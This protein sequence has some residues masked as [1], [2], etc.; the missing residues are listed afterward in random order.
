[1]KTRNFHTEFQLNGQS[2]HSIKE[3]KEFAENY[4]S[5][6]NQL[7][8]GWFSESDFLEI[9]TSGSTGKPKTI[10]L[11]KHHITNSVKATTEYFDINPGSKALLCLPLTYVAGK[12]MVLRSLISGWK[13]QMVEPSSNPLQGLTYNFD[14]AAMVP[15]QLENS[16][17]Q[18]NQI[19][20]LIVG[21]G[22]VSES[23]V[24]KIQKSEC[25]VFETYGMTETITHI[26][27]KRLN[28]FQY[29]PS[30]F[31]VLPNV[32]VFKDERDCLVI[33]APK[34]YNNLIVTNDVVQLISNNQFKW[35]GRIDNVINSGGIKLHPEEIEGKLK[36]ILNQRF[37]VTSEK[38]ER[39]GEKLMIVVE[40]KEVNLVNQLIIKIKE[41]EILTNFEKPRKIVLLEQF[42]ET[43][44]GKIRRSETLTQM[45]HIFEGEM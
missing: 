12:L 5:E 10:R 31:E 25:E 44:S 9:K 36:G 32:T 26:A 27:V 16:I 30:H 21:G 3:V 11:Q 42:L 18:L 22:K 29:F 2:F 41:L 34:I 20:K 24:E 19:K 28:Q 8:S 39:L 14:F 1:M 4:S 7:I 43:S 35:L 13:L 23:I 37:F 6:L 38:D 40:T 45:T 17:S 33:N 15:L